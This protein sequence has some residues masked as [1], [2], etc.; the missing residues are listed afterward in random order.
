MKDSFFTVIETEHYLSKAKK[1][2]TEK[3]R[4]EVVTIVAQEPE[5][6]EMMQGTGGVYKFRYASQEGKGK[7]GGAR[8]M[9]LPLVS[10]GKVY[11]LDIFE[12]NEKVNLTKGERNE[13]AKIVK[14]MKGK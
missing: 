7:R 1:T 3:Q 10:Q 12:K 2:L 14:V 4:D 13:L 9:H 11:L 5:I 8:I 6:G